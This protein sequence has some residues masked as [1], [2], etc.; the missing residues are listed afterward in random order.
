MFCQVA[1]RRAFKG[2][3][4]CSGFSYGDVLGAGEGWAQVDPVQRGRA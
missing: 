2:L 4:T 3:V 1:L